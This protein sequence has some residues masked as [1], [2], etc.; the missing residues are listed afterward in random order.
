MGLY[1]DKL[2]S[3]IFQLITQINTQIRQR[4]ANE[5]RPLSLLYHQHANSPYRT[6]FY[7]L[8][9]NTAKDYIFNLI[10]VYILNIILLWIIKS[11]YLDLYK[12]KIIRICFRLKHKSLKVIKKSINSQFYFPNF[13]YDNSNKLFFQLKLLHFLMLKHHNMDPCL[14]DYDQLWHHFVILY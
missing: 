5:N 13:W 11:V 6:W 4:D 12:N 14:M 3:T 7:T 1:K 9:S 8:Y 10:R 2:S